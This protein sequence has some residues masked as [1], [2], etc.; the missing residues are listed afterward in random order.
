MTKSSSNEFDYI[1]EN[2][3]RIREDIALCCAKAGRD[4]NEV[5]LMAVTKT[6]EAEKINI[7]LSE[8]I[9]LIGENKVQELLSKLPLLEPKTVEKHLIGHLQTNKVR[10]IL[11]RADMIES[12]DS[13]R[14]ASEISLEAKKRN[15]TADI[16]LE[17]NIGKEEAKS[18]FFPEDF[19]ENI[20]M[21]SEMSN[22]R[23]HGL[24]AIPPICA[25]NDEIRG[26]FYKMR[27]LFIDIQSKKIDNVDMHVL[28]L[29]MS[30]DY[31]EAILEGST[32]IR[33]GSSI[34]GE[35]NYK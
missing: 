3:K 22:I 4:E 16:L 15:I 29:G 35:R 32:L 14:L 31:K 34:F 6:V 26:Y 13:I 8:G 18:G 25:E 1:S 10:Q 11:G 27:K 9:D 33:V 2:I 24:M 12:V 7:A 23:V 5:R 21:I 30:G 28:S 20:H 17:V 19:I